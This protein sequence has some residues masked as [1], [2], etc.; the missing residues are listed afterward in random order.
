MNDTTPDGG[1]WDTFF[2]NNDSVTFDD[3]APKNTNVTV[4]DDVSV[5]TLTISGDEYNFTGNSKAKITGTTANFTAG[6]TDWNVA[7]QFAN[8]NVN[9]GAGIRP[10]QKLVGDVTF[11]QSNDTYVYLRS[12]RTLGEKLWSTG[13]ITFG[14]TTIVLEND[15]TLISE[16]DATQ[17]I[18]KSDTTDGLKLG[19]EILTGDHDT[20]TDA[21]GGTL[22]FTKGGKTLTIRGT[23]DNPLVFEKAE[24]DGKKL[25]FRWKVRT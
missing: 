22:S 19:T 20:K 7:S 25:A 18:V 14:N 8:Y 9:A 2:K 5:G 17:T 12:G 11:D 1:S 13:K 21:N 6:V 23:T 10:K 4:D 15:G 16:L 3:I 24:A